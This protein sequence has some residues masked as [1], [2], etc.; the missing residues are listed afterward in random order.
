M[1]EDQE[2]YRRVVLD[3]SRLNE[4]RTIAGID[5]KLVVAILM[6][7]GFAGMLFHAITILF[8]PFLLILFLRGPAKR[9]QAFVQIHL[10][11]RQQKLRYSPG[12]VTAPNNSSPRPHG[13]NRNSLT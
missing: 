7:F 2:A 1:S 3:C 12:Y 11:H 5:Y 10:R 4:P 9:D 6:F 8:L 13:F